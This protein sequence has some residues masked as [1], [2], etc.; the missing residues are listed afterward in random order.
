[1]KNKKTLIIFFFILILILL[2]MYFLIIKSDKTPQKADIVLP[3]MSQKI[4]NENPNY[5][6][7]PF[8]SAKPYEID[9]I[10]INSISFG[11]KDDDLYIKYNLNG[12]LPREEDL[13]SFDG[14]KIHG[15]I[16][17]M[18]LD[19]NYFDGYGN[20]NP[21]GA[22]AE[23]K[24]SFYGSDKPT[25]N[26][27][28]ISVNGELVDGGIGHD[29]FVAKYRYRELLLNQL[30]DKVV[31]TANSVALSKAYSAGA[32]IFYFQNSKKMASSDPNEILIELKPEN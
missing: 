13:P 22:E 21:G 11:I 27:N 25:E 1:M 31:F 26:G 20:K 2:S 7:S 15:A 8:G 14:D 28:K 4:E 16:F 32:S 9:F 18:T 30:G 17:Y 19:D 23:L 5:A 6:S 29:Y 10:K 24:M 3:D 12:I